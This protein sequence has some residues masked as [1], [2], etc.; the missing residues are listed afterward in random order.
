VSLC[1][2]FW[3]YHLPAVHNFWFLFCAAFLTSQEL[4]I[5]HLI[6]YL[7]CWNKPM[8]NSVTM[9]KYHTF[10]FQVCLSNQDSSVTVIIILFCHILKAKSYLLWW[11]F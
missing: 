6:N 2:G 3:R 4:Q 10:C 11:H 1:V 8:S 9:K 5:I 7:F